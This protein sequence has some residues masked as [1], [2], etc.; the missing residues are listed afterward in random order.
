MGRQ[1]K[2]TACVHE[3]ADVYCC[4]VESPLTDEK[5]LESCSNM[6]MGFKCALNSHS[7]LGW[8]V[9]S[10]LLAAV[11]VL[12]SPTRKELDRWDRIVYKCKKLGRINN[13]NLMNLNSQITM[14]GYEMGRLNK[15]FSVSEY[16]DMDSS[17]R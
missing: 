2:S 12:R 11:R 5:S 1:C 17:S 6:I 8:A 7:F 9:E 4:P 15:C 13:F 14:V 16:G 3:I 10:E